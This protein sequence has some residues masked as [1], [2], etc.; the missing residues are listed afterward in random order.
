MAKIVTPP[1]AA[2]PAI[3]R[4]AAVPARPAP[5][6][7]PARPTAA[8]ARPAAPAAAARPAMT[9]LQKKLKGMKDIWNKGKEE[10]AK[11][12]P[13]GGTTLTVG[14]HI[15]QLT[16]CVLKEGDNGPYVLFEFTCTDEA[17]PEIGEKAVRFAGMDTEDRVI[18]LQRDLRRLGM[19][20]DEFDIE[21]LED[22]LAALLEQAPTVSL[23]VKENE[24]NGKSYINVYVNKLINDAAEQPVEEAVAEEPEEPTEEPAAEEEPAEEPAEGEPEPEPQADVIEIGDDVRYMDAKGKPQTGMIKGVTD[25]ATGVI[26]RDDITKKNVTVPIE[27]IE[28]L[29]T[30]ATDD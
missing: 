9:A 27:K 1:R 17:D 16:E 11:P 8:P 13:G 3:A 20:V 22:R 26:V 25:D 19:D 4:P 23:Q 12:G 28:K 24:S 18:Y 7:A 2:A 10:S 5:A 15:C 29:A 30:P 6:V 14:R 21:Q